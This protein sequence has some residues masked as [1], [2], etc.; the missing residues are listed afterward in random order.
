MNVYFPQLGVA[1]VARKTRPKNATFV[2][3][4]SDKAVYVIPAKTKPRGAEVAKG[5]LGGWNYDDGFSV[6]LVYGKTLSDMF[7][8]RMAEN[9]RWLVKP[10]PVENGFVALIQTYTG[11]PLSAGVTPVVLK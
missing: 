4:L 9:G 6:H 2:G 11:V 7:R 5:V 1:V 10:Q 8:Y 3:Y